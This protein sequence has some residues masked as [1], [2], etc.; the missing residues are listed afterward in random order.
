M[1]KCHLLATFLC[2]LVVSLFLAPAAHATVRRAV[3]EQKAYQTGTAYYT[4]SA[5]ITSQT[6]PGTSQVAG[7]TV[8]TNTDG[9]FLGT[10][11][12]GASTP[13]PYKVGGSFQSD[14]S[15]SLYIDFGTNQHSI[16][17]GIAYP[18]RFSNY[19]GNFA[20][21]GTAGVVQYSGTWGLTPVKDPLHIVSMTFSALTIAGP[22]QGTAYVGVMILD[23]TSTYGTIR[24]YD[25]RIAPVFAKI[26]QEKATFTFLLDNLMFVVVTGTP[27]IVGTVL[28][29]T[30]TF[31]GPRSGDNGSW[32]SYPFTFAA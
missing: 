12:K 19:T 26:S 4:F 13:L 15:I 11:V 25:G 5:L 21:T 9:T 23:K 2:A 3:E 18:H 31:T 24:L 14:G 16:W 10:L 17:N 6:P 7:L 28:K 29:Y 30:G 20:V 1:K 8:H 27:S 32:N 22:D